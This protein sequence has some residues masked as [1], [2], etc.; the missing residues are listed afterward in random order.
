MREFLTAGR[1]DEPVPDRS[2]FKSVLVDVLEGVIE[3]PIRD[4][5]LT[6]EELGLLMKNTVAT[7]NPSQHPQYGKILDPELDKG[8]FVFVLKRTATSSPPSPPTSGPETEALLVAG[9]AVLAPWQG[10]ECLYAG[11]VLEARGAGVLV[12]F[13]FGDEVRM[14]KEDLYLPATP[15][16]SALRLSLDVYVALDERRSTWAPGKLKEQRG[17]ELLVSLDSSSCAAGRPHVWA[18]RQNLVLRN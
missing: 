11:T 7:Y 9:T 12:R 4:G 16:P 5:F 18:T 6:G 14:T 17:D 2:V 10:D 15:L 1:A 3:E 8:D 13:D